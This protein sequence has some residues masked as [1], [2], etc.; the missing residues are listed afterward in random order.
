MRSSLRILYAPI[1]LLAALMI[2]GCATTREQPFMFLPSGKTIPTMVF[3]NFTEVEDAY[4]KVTEGA[5]TLEELKA[6]GF[7]PW[8]NSNA[9]VW[10]PLRVRDYLR[11]PH[12]TDNMAL[13]QLKPGAQAC[14]AQAGTAWKFNFGFTKTKGER[15]AGD[16]IK[17]EMGYETI[18]HITGA[19]L[20]PWFCFNDAGVVLHKVIDAKPFIDETKVSTDKFAPFRKALIGVGAALFL[21]L[22]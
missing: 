11:G 15:S 13:D 1:A 4:A 8:R 18:D 6:L 19:E 17:R 14:L 7:D 3:K 5:T 9:E 10:N 22:F 16:W 21:L 12:Q 20:Q 2:T